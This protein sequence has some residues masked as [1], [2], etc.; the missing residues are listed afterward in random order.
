MNRLTPPSTASNREFDPTAKDPI[1]GRPGA[2]V[3]RP[4]SLSQNYWKDFQPRVGVAW[5]FRPRIV[6]RGNFG[7]ITQDLFMTSLGQNFEEYFATAAVQSPVGDPRPAFR[8][9]Q[10]P[11]AGPVQHRR[12]RQRAFRRDQLL[13]PECLLDR[14]QYPPAHTS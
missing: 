9:S 12:G 7:I 8:L 3:H 1:S 14:S 2:I 6:F 5:N 4:G 13:Q 11:G 10:G